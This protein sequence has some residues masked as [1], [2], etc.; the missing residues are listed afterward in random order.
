VQH[1]CIPKIL[2]GED[3]IA[4]A[5]TGSGKTAAFA[6]PIIQ[7]LSEDPYGIYALV[8]TPTRELAY[9]IA[10][11]FRIIGK[12]INVN[13]WILFFQTN[14]SLVTQFS[15]KILDC[16]ITGGME[17][18]EQAKQLANKPHI[19]IATPGR[20]AD[21]IESGTDFTLNKIQMLVLDEADRLL[22]D[23]F[24][25][26]LQTIFNILPKKRQTLLFSATIT[27]T[28][29]KLQELSKKTPFLFDAQSE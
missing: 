21:H 14:L 27:D 9:Q 2:E 11:Q 7:K 28:I 17:M 10:D 29:K 26:Q 4:C 20:L 25:D 23:N 22:E 16:V 24:G 3:I 15:F 19:L 8:L 6:L 12:P 1:H 5:K 13:T 18:T